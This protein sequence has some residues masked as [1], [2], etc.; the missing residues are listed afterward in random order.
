MI[1]KVT[2]SDIIIDFLYDPGSQYTMIP[3]EVYDKLN[4]RPPLIPLEKSGM[5]VDGHKFSLLG[6]VYLNLKLHQTDGTFYTIEYEPVLV[7]ENID[8]PIYGLHSEK[9]FVECN[10][11]TD[12]MILTYV[13]KESKTPIM[14]KMFHESCENYSSLYVKV[15]KTVIIPANHVGTHYQRR[16]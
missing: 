9:A 2:V 5:G 6:I 4:F 7:S 10:R 1:I 14:V 15:A 11:K 12:N 16:Y 13:A 3:K 8:T